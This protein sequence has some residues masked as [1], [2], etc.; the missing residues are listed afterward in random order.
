MTLK[1]K[2]VKIS[3]ATVIAATGIAIFGTHLEGFSKDAAASS[4]ERIAEYNISESITSGAEEARIIKTE[5]VTAK[6]ERIA[7][8]KAEVKRVA[9]QVTAEAKAAEDAKIAQVQEQERV[10]EVAKAEEN[11]RVQTETK[12]RAQSQAV[13]AAPAARAP[14]ANAPATTNTVPQQ[15]PAAV[16]PVAPIINTNVIN[17]PLAGGQA[18]VD[19]C[20]GPV[21]FTP[22]QQTSVIAEHDGCGGWQRFGNMQQGSIVTVTGK[23]NGSYRIGGRANIAKGSNT[24]VI[25]NNFGGFPPLV[26]QTC[27]PGTDRMIITAAYPV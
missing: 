17:V 14:V 22:V 16:A 23:V 20:Q 3:A 11:V 5:A 2:V 13:A 27:I 21:L 24:D 7:A 18:V 8:E 26:F 10:A 6:R 9:D 12:A 19:L 15:A 1:T 4:T 25:K